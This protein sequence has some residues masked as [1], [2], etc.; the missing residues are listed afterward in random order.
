M[1]Y[2][3]ARPVSTRY[4][5]VDESKRSGYV[6]AATTVSDPETTRRVV[7]SLV[8]PGQ[9]RIHMKQEQ[10]RRRRV[11]VSSLVTTPVETTIYDAGRGYRTDLAA[12]AAC[13]AALVDDLAAAGDTRLVLEQDDSLVRSDRHELYQLV[14]Q[15][16]ITDILEYR[17][18]RVHEEPLLAFPDVVAWCWV[19][20]ADWRR[21]IR[22]ILT[23]VRRLEP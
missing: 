15:A 8:L 2:E 6:L 1:T 23:N 21:R 14:R 16:G 19:R 22:P 4:V 10:P 17:H 11:I 20:S 3:P 13:L 5:Y 12:R 9:R 7:R 18:Q